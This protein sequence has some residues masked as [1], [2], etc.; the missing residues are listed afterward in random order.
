MRIGLITTIGTNIGDTLIREGICLVLKE[1]FGGRDLEFVLVNKH[2]PLTVYPDGHPVRAAVLARYLPRGRARAASAIE[3]LASKLN[4]SRFDGCDLIVQCGTPVLWPGCH[5]CEWAVPIWHHVVGRLS[6]RIPVLNIAAGA[7][8]PWERQPSEVTDPRDIE[9]LRA[10]TS[11]CRTTTVR[12]R[13]A[14]R[15]FQAMD[16]EAPLVPCSALLAAGRNPT[17]NGGDGTVLIDYMHGGGHYDWDQRIDPSAW[18]RTMRNLIERLK[19]RHNLVFLCHDEKEYGLAKDLDPTLR[20]MWPKDPQEY[21]DLVATA[22]GAI[23]NR[24]HASV[25]LASLG[26]PS[27]AVCTDTR[28]LMVEALG[29]PCL[30]VKEATADR[31][32]DLLEHLLARRAQEKARLLAL[33]TETWNRYVEVFSR[34]MDEKE[35]ARHDLCS[36]SV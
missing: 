33:R 23:C 20:R 18:A 34:A 3:R 35:P 25:A 21:F 17:A 1:V 16:I 26:I 24:M 15:L 12:D 7:C 19:H 27:I 14:H 22:S 32:E 2:A 5:R 6:E 8:Y 30:Y 4:M 11:Y 10:I 9:Y 29:L 31:L 28:L 36:V 13:L